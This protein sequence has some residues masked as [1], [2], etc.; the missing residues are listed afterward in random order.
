MLFTQ[1]P[2]TI[3]HFLLVSLF[4]LLF[5]VSSSFVICHVAEVSMEAVQRLGAVCKG[6]VG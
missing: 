6:F 3:F 4:P 5:S 1:I 2:F